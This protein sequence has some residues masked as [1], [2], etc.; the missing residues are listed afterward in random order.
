MAAGSG[1]VEQIDVDDVRV[2][3]ALDT[4]VTADGIIFRRLPS[5]TRHQIMDIQLG[6][7]ITMPAGVRLE[8]VTDATEIEVDVLLDAARAGRAAGE[9]GGV[10]PRRR[11]RGGRLAGVG[12]RSPDPHRIRG[13]AVRVRSRRSHDDP[14]HGCADRREH[15]GRAVVAAGCRRRAARGARVRRRDSGSCPRARGGD[16]FTTAARSAIASKRAGPRRPG[17]RSRRGARA[18]TC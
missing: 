4:D 1:A 9:A 11:R 6:F 3:G 10:R 2:A 7:V 17:P 15:D 18:S 12:V 16:G 13:R 14:L 8:F 5:W